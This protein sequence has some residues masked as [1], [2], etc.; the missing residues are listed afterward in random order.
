M[1]LRPFRLQL[2]H[3]LPAMHPL[4]FSNIEKI[5]DK[6]HFGLNLAEMS[7]FEN[8]EILQ[9]LVP[10]IRLGFLFI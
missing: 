1:N 2:A 3:F 8:L 7:D 6:I 4:E 5:S 10:S 9:N